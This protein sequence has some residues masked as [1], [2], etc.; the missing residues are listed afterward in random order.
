MQ[1]WY[2]FHWMSCRRLA[3]VLR[4]IF[5]ERQ[6]TV[7][8]GDISCRRVKSGLN[9]QELFAACFYVDVRRGVRTEQTPF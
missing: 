1:Q 3:R 9:R 6:Y 2:K 7:V 8:L 4:G 5:R